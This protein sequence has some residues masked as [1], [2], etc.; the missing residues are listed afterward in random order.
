MGLK[1]ELMRTARTKGI[2]LDGFQTMHSANSKEALVA[3]YL[4]TPDWS[5]ERSFPRLDVLRQHFADCQEQ[6]V[7]IDATFHGETFSKLQTYVFHNCKGVINVEMDYAEAN[8]PMLYFAND[9]HVE[10]VCRQQQGEGVPAIRIPM[11]V[12]GENVVTYEDTDNAVFQRYDF[13]LL[14]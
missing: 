12:F 14:T 9:C 11:Y 7:Y 13:E 5:L 4:Q 6:G 10:I 8:I 3:Y 1:E 2:C